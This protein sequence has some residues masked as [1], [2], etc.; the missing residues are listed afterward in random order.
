MA[1]IDVKEDWQGLGAEIDTDSAAAFRIFTVKFDTADEPIQRPVLA[2]S[3][4]GIPAINTAHPYKPWL[5]VKNKNVESIGPFDFE[6]KVYYSTRSTIGGQEG[7]TQD[8]TANPLED[9][10][11]I[12]WDFVTSNEPIDTDIDG[13]PITNSANESFD[14]P[15]T[16]D[17]HDLL[18]R[19]Q[20]N[21][22]A[23]NPLVAHSYKKATNSDYF[24]G[25]EPG[26]V[27]CVQFTGKT[28]VRG[29]FWYWQVRYAFQMRGD[30]WLRR[31]RDEGY[32]TKTG[33]LNADGSEKYKEIKDIDGMKLSQPA[34]LNGE[35]Y[36]LP[37]SAIDAGSIA[38]LYFKLNKPLPF[39]ALGL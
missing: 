1:V 29:Q 26:I 16:T 21:E 18:L 31:I 35:G 33:E 8:P 30:G 14:P 9:P 24:W 7:E 39:S 10:W 5:F 19:I 17:V 37:Q 23:F 20:R 25:F 22:A 32:R 34:L 13:K 38:F 36:R 15:I 27:K 11:I 4:T 28:A 12:E 2:Y 3:A 6:V